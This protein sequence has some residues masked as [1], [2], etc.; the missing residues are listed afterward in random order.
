MGANRLPNRGRGLCVCYSSLK[1]K[2]P[3]AK[4]MQWPLGILC[5]GCKVFENSHFP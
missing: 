2:M 3:L 5:L 1:I 4:R